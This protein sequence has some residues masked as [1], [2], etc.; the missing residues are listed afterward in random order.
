MATPLVG[1]SPHQSP[2]QASTQAWLS[3]TA[4]PPRPRPRRRGGGSPRRSGPGC[5]AARST[6]RARWAK[7][8]QTPAPGVEGLGGRGVHA[9][10][11]AHVLEGVVRPSRPPAR[12]WPPG[13]RRAAPAATSARRGV[14]LGVAAG[15][16]E[17]GVAVGGRRHLV[18]GAAGGAGR[19]L[20]LHQRPSRGSTGVVGAVDVEGHDLGA[21]VVPVRVLG[22]R[23]AW[24]G[25][26]PRAWSGAAWS[27]A[28]L[29]HLVVRGPGQ[30]VE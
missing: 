26:A 3:P 19:G 7:S 15:G 1:S 23:W 8:W 4:P 24:C 21:P 14:G 28:A 22:R 11:P 30:G 2:V 25:S 20:G 6:A 29:A 18:P 16:E 12:R 27:P 10:H 5:P 9:G 17:L 13:C